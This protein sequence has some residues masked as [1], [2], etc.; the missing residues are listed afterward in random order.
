MT[1]FKN[2]MR[3]KVVRLLVGK[4]LLTIISLFKTCDDVNLCSCAVNKFDARYQKLNVTY[5]E[6]YTECYNHRHEKR[7]AKSNNVAL[8]EFFFL[9]LM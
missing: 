6:I 8:S 9:Y 3:I 1:T 2:Y 4:K 7:Q 5:G